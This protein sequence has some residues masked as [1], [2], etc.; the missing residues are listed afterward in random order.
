M[1]KIILFIDVVA[2][3]WGGRGSVVFVCGSR[4]LL[5]SQFVDF[6]NPIRF[7]F[8][9]STPVVCNP[10]RI[11]TT[12]T[13]RVPTTTTRVPTTTIRIPTT[14]TLVPTT[15]L[16]TT[17]IT[18][19]ST[20]MIAWFD[21]LKQKTWNMLEGELLSISINDDGSVYGTN[22]IF[23]VYFKSCLTCPWSQI[24][25]KLR[26]I[27]SKS[28]DLV[29]GVSPIN[30]IFQYTK[31]KGFEKLGSEAR[32]ASIGVDGEI[33]MTS[34]QGNIYR[35]NK[36]ASSKTWILVSGKAD[37]I[38]VGNY[39]NVYIKNSNMEVLQYKQLVA[40]GLKIDSWNLLPKTSSV[41]ILVVSA[42]SDG[43]LLGNTQQNILVVWNGNSW[44]NASST[45]TNMKY[46]SV[47]STGKFFA[48]TNSLG[49]IYY[50]ANY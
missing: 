36:K 17:T 45:L 12:T 25:G 23:D 16:P 15:K 21:R 24:P 7:R 6:N 41:D 29:V 3:F 42:S 43:K 26:Q 9:V 22:S 50:T 18:T 37:I 39:N 14:T 31:T 27:D 4:I 47:S 38:T 35:W 20:P 40:L 5:I 10:K 19:T 32:W 28:A 46:I 49:Q 30:E 48:S 1:I 44:Q 34:L 8:T 33:W 11:T 2:L 13:T